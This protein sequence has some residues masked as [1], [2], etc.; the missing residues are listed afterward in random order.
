MQAIRA[1]YHAGVFTP[2]EPVDLPDGQHVLVVLDPAAKELAPLGSEDHA[3]LL[4]QQFEEL[5]RQWK[6]ERGPTSS[7]VKMAAHPAYRQIIGMGQAAIPLL[8]AEL[9][10]QPDHWFIALHEITGVDP[11]PKELRGQLMEMTAA[12]L[13]WGH[14]HGVRW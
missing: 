9:E 3:F 10:R 11:V 5:V 14:A 13:R 8:L 12:W 1:T 7:V 2:E 6:K 4:K